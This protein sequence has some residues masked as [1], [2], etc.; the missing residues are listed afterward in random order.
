MKSIYV[1]VAVWSGVI[2]ADDCAAFSDHEDAVA[3]ETKLCKEW[4]YDPDG[5][6]SISILG[7]PVDDPEVLAS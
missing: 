6:H 2:S 4:N 3:Y 5:P 1:V 7:L